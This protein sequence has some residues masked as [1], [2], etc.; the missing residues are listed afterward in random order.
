MFA[1]RRE[2]A[3]LLV[4]ELRKRKAEFD[5]VLGIPAGGMVLAEV[6]ATEFSCPLDVV[7]AKKIGHPLNPEVAIGA[8]TPDGE[9]LIA[10]EN[11]PV[12]GGEKEVARLG[13]KT[14]EL[15]KAVLSEYRKG[16]PQETIQG[17][18]VLLVDDGIATG[19][20]MQAAIKYVR[21]QGAKTVGLAAPV[22]SAEA[23]RILEPELDYSIVL[24]VPRTFLAVG[25]HYRDF[26]PVSK[27]EVMRIL[28]KHS[29]TGKTA[30]DD[31]SHGKN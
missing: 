22:S 15:V 17:K 16:K 9:V 31:F 21:R 2:A 14:S 28:A 4:E 20:T 6:I 3:Y 27:E 24:T 7:T 30:S 25:S 18:N 8:V 1:H 10:P 19:L 29:K 5:L 13:R 26:S 11:L 23:L 12:L